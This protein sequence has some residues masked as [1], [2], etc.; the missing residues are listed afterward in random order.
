MRWLESITNSMDMNLSKLQEIVKDRGSW[1]ATVHGVAKS[2]T[3]LSNW[4]ITTEQS[5]PWILAQVNS[6]YKFPVIPNMIISSLKQN[7]TSACVSPSCL[8]QCLKYNGN[9]RVFC[10]LLDCY[11]FVWFSVINHSVPR[12]SIYEDVTSTNSAPKIMWR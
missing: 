1:C 10:W 4:K 6:S 12:F 2:W 8:L 3:R 7:N 5:Q 9:W 11:G